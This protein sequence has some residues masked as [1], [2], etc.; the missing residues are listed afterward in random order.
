MLSHPSSFIHFHHHQCR[1]KLTTNPSP[2]PILHQSRC[3]ATA[4]CGTPTPATARTP[5]WCCRCCS[6]T[7]RPRSCCSIRAPARTWRDSSPTQVSAAAVSATTPV[8][9]APRRVIRKQGRRVSKLR[10]LTLRERNGSKLAG[11]G[12]GPISMTLSLFPVPLFLFVRSEWKACGT[13]RVD[14]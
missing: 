2:P 13:W 14:Q 11:R 3:Y 7:C 10:P 1:S 12:A 4:P 9:S 5:R 8:G 6:R